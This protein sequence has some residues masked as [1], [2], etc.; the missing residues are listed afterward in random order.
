MASRQQNVYDTKVIRTDDQL[1]L[2]GMKHWNTWQAFKAS[3]T[4]TLDA[5]VDAHRYMES[6]QLKGKIVV[7]V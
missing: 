2:I 5:I 1:S 4:F 3:R 7:T 6:N